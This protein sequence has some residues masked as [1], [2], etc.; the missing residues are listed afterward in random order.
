MHLL[1]A[2]DDLR[3]GLG[4]LWGGGDRFRLVF[5]L[6]AFDL[7]RGEF[8]TMKTKMRINANDT[9]IATA[10]GHG[11]EIRYMIK[12]KKKKHFPYSSAERRPPDRREYNVNIP[13]TITAFQERQVKSTQQAGKF[14]GFLQTAAVDRR[15]FSAQP[16]R[17]LAILNKVV[18]A[19]AACTM[20]QRFSD[21]GHCSRSKSAGVRLNWAVLG[22]RTV[23]NLSPRLIKLV[24]KRQ[25][26]TW[27]NYRMH[28][29]RAAFVSIYF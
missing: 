17:R 1:K 24:Q 6:F 16:E 8:P 23:E 2:W 15:V 9:P 19:A 21:F 28:N 11:I 3:L 10:A 27:L 18:T 13:N 7:W 22:G 20:D 25:Y 5:L 12:K 26:I 29:E 14:H 4:V